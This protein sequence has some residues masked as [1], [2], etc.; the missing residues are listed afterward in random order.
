MWPLAPPY[1]QERGHTRSR[2]LAGR[3]TAAWDRVAR[4]AA[5]GWIGRESG[6]TP[7]SRWAT[8]PCSSRR[9]RLGP[10]GALKRGAMCSRGARMR[11]G[12]RG[13]RSGW[14]L[15]ERQR[16]RCRRQRV[17]AR[18]HRPRVLGRR[19]EPPQCR[20]VVGAAAKAGGTGGRHSRRGRRQEGAFG[21]PPSPVR[22]LS[23]ADVTLRDGIPITTPRRTISDLRRAVARGAAGGVGERELRRAIRQANV[24]GLPADEEAKRDRTRSDLER[25]FL[26]ICRRHRSAVARGQRPRRALPDRLP[27]AG[28]SVGGRDRQ[29]PLPPRPPGL[30]GR[31]GA[32]LRPASTRLE[33]DPAFRKADRRGT[34][35]GC[36][37]ARRCP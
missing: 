12:Q 31:S 23:D 14:C 34:G 2:D 17:R 28:A 27:L 26:R 18:P 13:P 4:S 37:G 16:N 20:R 36:E 22:S 3:R 32:R 21:N 1:G 24:L 19:R 5:C 35:S 6:A 8:A 33:R 29:L 10:L 25:D 30:R 7:S 15:H 11:T 9:I